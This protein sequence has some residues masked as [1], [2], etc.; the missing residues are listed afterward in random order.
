MEIPHKED[1]EKFL[2][3]FSN[4][5]KSIKEI[6]FFIYGSYLRDDFVPGVSDLN[7]FLVLNDPFITNKDTITSL[8]SI[9][10]NSLKVSNT[11]IRT[12]FNIFDKGIAADGRFL[13]HSKDYVDFLKKNA[14][15]KYGEYDLEDMDGSDYKSPE[16]VSISS[17]LNNIR[18]G[19]FYREF[20]HYLNKRDFYEEVIMKLSQFPRQLI[21]ISGEKLIE[22]KEDS[23]KA[24]L[25]NFSEYKDSSLVNRVNELM[26]DPFKY[27]FFLEREEGFPFSLKCLTEMETMIKVYVEKFPKM[28]ASEVK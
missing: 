16:R 4:E 22:E 8:A 28:V 15:R 18:K 9:L 7:G 1:Y 19:F 14:V 24:F 2:Y 5:L 27:E 26:K 25:K 10:D 20:N 13:V 3:E 23:L 21:N 12:K 6:S 17:N 11:R